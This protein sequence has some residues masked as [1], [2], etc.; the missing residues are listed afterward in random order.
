MRDYH[1]STL[2]SVFL[3]FMSGVVSRLIVK[4]RKTRTNHRVINQEQDSFTN[5][6]QVKALPRAISS[7][8]FKAST[9]L[10]LIHHNTH[11]VKSIKLKLIKVN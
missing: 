11:H 5:R 4:L 8:S 3:H 7:K 2:F 10:N 6:L 1:Q 9:M